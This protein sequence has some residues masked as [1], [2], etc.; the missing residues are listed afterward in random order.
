MPA[1]QMGEEVEI[2][3]PMCWSSDVRSHCQSHGGVEEMTSGM[4][5]VAFFR[6]SNAVFPQ[7]F[8]RLSNDFTKFSPLTV[9][10]VSLRT[11][12]GS[13]TRDFCTELF[14]ILKI[15]LVLSHIIFSVAMY[16]VKNKRLF[17]EN[18]EFYNTKP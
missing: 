5:A 4:S 1:F 16:V 7:L 8:E 14:K 18:P 15:L 17:M 3:R 11:I 9:Y 6:A 2:W 10:C 13:R 12:V